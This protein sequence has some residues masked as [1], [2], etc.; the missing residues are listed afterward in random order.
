MNERLYEGSTVGGVGVVGVGDIHT[1]AL[2][3]RRQ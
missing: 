1:N 3:Y 2:H